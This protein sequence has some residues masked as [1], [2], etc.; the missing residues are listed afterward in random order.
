MK[1]YLLVGGAESVGKTGAIWRLTDYLLNPSDPLNYKE[2]IDILPPDLSKPP[3]LFNPKEFQFNPLKQKAEDIHK[4]FRAITLN[5]TKNGKD[6]HKDFMAKLSGTVQKGKDILHIAI[7]SAT[8]NK[9]LI[10]NFKKFI[11]GDKNISI[12]ISSI[13]DNDIDPKIICSTQGGDFGQNN[14]EKCHSC[15]PKHPRKCFFCELGIR[16]DKDDI[17]IELPLAKIEEDQ[18]IPPEQ[19]KISQEWY[20]KH[21]DIMLKI[22][23]LPQAKIN[24]PEVDLK[25][26]QKQKEIS[27]EWYKNNI[28]IMLKI[29]VKVLLNCPEDKLEEISNCWWSVNCPPPDKRPPLPIDT[30]GQKTTTRT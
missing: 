16:K 22:I 30:D 5:G 28:D 7:N 24:G 6:I 12:I 26:F 2:F 19:K 29:L 9:T 17:V 4:Y 10:R 14:K 20:K 13:R 11:D 23:K 25:I 15:E 1:K 8:D 18:K 27:L 3:Y 21:S